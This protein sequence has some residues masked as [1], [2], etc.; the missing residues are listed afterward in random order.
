MIKFFKT[1]I[2][3]LLFNKCNSSQSISCNNNCN[4]IF[5]NTVDIQINLYEDKI[6]FNG[7]INSNNNFIIGFPKKYNKYEDSDIILIENNIDIKSFTL[8]NNTLFLKNNYFIDYMIYK[9]NNNIIFSFN[10]FL[11]TKKDDDT[12]IYFN[13]EQPFFCVI[14]DF[15]NIKIY[16]YKQHNITFLKTYQKFENNNI[17]SLT[18]NYITFSDYYLFFAYYGIFILIV[19]ISYILLKLNISYNLNLKYLGIISLQL[20]LFIIFYTLLWLCLGIYTFI[21]FNFS[22]ILHKQ[23]LWINLN[24]ASVLLPITRNSIWSVLF[25]LS[26]INIRYLHKFMSILCIISVIIKIIVV[27][28]YKDFNYLFI[29][30]NET[31]GGSPLAGTIATFAFILMGVLSISHIR[32]NFFEV[33]YYSHKILF[34]IIIISSILHY[35]LVLFYILPTFMLYLIDIYFRNKYTIK[36]AHTTLK[37]TG[38]EKY[39]TS[40]ILIN[41]ETL[42]KIKIPAGSFFFL[43]YRDISRFEWHPLSVVFE[44]NNNILFCA[45]DMGQNSWTNHLKNYDATLLKKEILLNRNVYLQGPYQCNNINYKKYE[46]MIFIAGGIGITPIISILQDINKLKIQGLLN[47]KKIIFIWVIPHNSMIKVFNSIFEKLDSFIQIIIYSTNKFLLD[48]ENELEENIIYEDITSSLY[49]TIIYQRPIISQEIEQ[50]FNSFNTSVKNVSLV[51]CGPNSL[52]NDVI[53]TCF[54]LNIK[55]YNE[56]F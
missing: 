33:F 35:I 19:C 8:K 45:K 32:N 18:Y 16:N 46:Y 48:L 26:H 40:C 25:K 36:S 6:Y 39:N 22:D 42:K 47:I 44:S 34:V 14:N 28:C 1:I 4:L 15:D 55:F 10:R 52:S 23:G 7:E 27:L 37:I 2:C 51:C 43:C 5:D 24:L 21:P 17:L 20:L 31:T 50:H 3:F 56:N 53:K 49:Y 29:L 13:K 11:D 12:T 30:Q 54:K 9:N 38:Y 41:I